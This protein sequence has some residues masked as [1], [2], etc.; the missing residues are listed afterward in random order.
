M[1]YADFGYPLA[2]T[3]FALHLGS[4]LGQFP[5]TSLENADVLVYGGNPQAVISK[6]Q[7]LRG[8]GKRVEMSLSELS[9]QAAEEFA[10][11]KNIPVLCRV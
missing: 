4:I 11:K 8:Q 3:G 9:E 2:A 6:S 5:L 1:L 7:E 10:A